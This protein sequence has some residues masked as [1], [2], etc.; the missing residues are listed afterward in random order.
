MTSGVRLAICLVV[1]SAA[2]VVALLL[3]G[4]DLAPL[5]GWDAATVVFDAWLIRVIATAG[6][7]RTKELAK[8]EDSSAPVADLV[9]LL[10][11]VASLFGVGLLL[12]QG[13]QEGGPSPSTAIAVSLVTVVLSWTVVHLVFTTRYA[14]LYFA[15][16]AGGID[17]N[18]KDQ[19]RY[20]DF[21]YLAF[22]I[23][24]TFQVSDTDLTDKKIRATA[25]RHALLAYLFGAVI[26]AS[27]INL[28]AGLA[29]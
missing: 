21:A 17:F 27:T 15:G 11:A 25:L 10:A 22:T 8:T 5:V 14:R 1:G 6:Q 18:E 16:A 7:S 2:A 9:L 12:V 29:K 23:G 4:K 26:L 24:M 3:G 13:A 19:P 20:T 28:V